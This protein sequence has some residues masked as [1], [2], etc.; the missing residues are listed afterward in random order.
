MTSPNDVVILSAA[1]TPLG[2][3]T[4]AL[5]PLSAVQLG[6]IALRRALEQSGVGAD[7]VDT[8]IALELT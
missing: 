1:R 6:T 7:A 2:K 5:A 8:V 4:G 3:I